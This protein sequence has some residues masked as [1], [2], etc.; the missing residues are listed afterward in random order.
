MS[1]TPERWV[2]ERVEKEGCIP[3]I[4]LRG[5]RVL[6]RYWDTISNQTFEVDQETL[7]HAQLIADAPRLKD[8]NEWLKSLNAEMLAALKLAHAQMKE[9]L[10]G[11][12]ECGVAMAV[13]EA[14][15]KAESEKTM[16]E[17]EERDGA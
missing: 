9:W 10:P 5:C 3:V 1:H 13:Q 11:L 7:D 6:C 8:E 16:N 15:A 2:W 14:I 4:T 12:M 17:V